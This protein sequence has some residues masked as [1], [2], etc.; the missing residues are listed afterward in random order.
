M[1]YTLSKCISEDDG[2]QG[3]SGGRVKRNKECATKVRKDS[4]LLNDGERDSWV[5]TILIQPHRS[6][7][8]TLQKID[9]EDSC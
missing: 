2:N 7:D 9:F 6:L 3:G 8:T 4:G 5:M 1:Y